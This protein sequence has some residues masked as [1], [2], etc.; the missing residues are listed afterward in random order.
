[1]R[2]ETPASLGSMK[3][4]DSRTFGISGLRAVSRECNHRFPATPTSELGKCGD[5]FSPQ[6][7][8]RGRRGQPD[9]SGSRSAKARRGAR[10][11]EG[12]SLTRAV[13]DFG[14]STSRLCHFRL[15]PFLRLIS[16]LLRLVRPFN[17]RPTAPDSLSRSPISAK[18]AENAPRTSLSTHFRQTTV[19]GNHRKSPRWQSPLPPWPKSPT[20]R[21]RLTPSPFAPS[22][23]SCQADPFAPS[24]S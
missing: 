11:R 7:G 17:T 18:S 3:M 22:R 10:R 21:V 20:A 23:R 15:I 9:T 14:Q 2:D 19:L 24:P 5:P 16:N 6:A 1:M 13:G 12:V 8:R 4:P